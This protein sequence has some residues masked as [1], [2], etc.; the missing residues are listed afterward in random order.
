V[1]NSS[2]KSYCVDILC[3]QIDARYLQSERKQFPFRNRDGRAFLRKRKILLK[4][5][6]ALSCSH[7]RK[8]CFIRNPWDRLLSCYIDKISERPKTT[9]W[10]IIGV[11]RGFHKKFGNI[12]YAGMKFLDFVDAVAEIPDDQ[13]D[14]HFRS[15]YTFFSTPNYRFEMD[16]I[17]YLERISQDFEAV[18]TLCGFPHSIQFP[19]LLKKR[20]D[21]YKNYYSKSL[22]V[23]V[24][25][26]YETDIKMF[27]YG[28][29]ST[30]PIKDGS[31]PA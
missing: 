18:R 6:D 22:I 25:Y 23:K 4:V 10:K 1:E 26:R 31:P 11:H 20:H 16:F 8:F 15:Q 12:F 5:E 17:G 3:N 7:Y 21:D 19:H 30:P 29:D 14:R 27:G 24:G 13:A 28:F 9:Q 2:F